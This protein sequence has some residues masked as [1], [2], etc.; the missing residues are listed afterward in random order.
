M[1]IFSWA[2]GLLAL[3][4]FIISISAM[5]ISFFVT[6]KKV[7]KVRNTLTQINGDVTDRLNSIRLIK[8]SG[9]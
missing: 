6:R 5:F 1:I 8:S 4:I 3:T 9:T 2:I 7:Y